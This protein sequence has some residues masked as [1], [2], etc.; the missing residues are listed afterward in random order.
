MWVQDVFL[1]RLLSFPHQTQ[2]PG[3]K[4]SPRGK[5]FLSIRLLCQFSGWLR[6]GLYFHEFI[7]VCSQLLSSRTVTTDH[8]EVGGTI[9]KTPPAGRHPLTFQAASVILL[10]SAP[11]EGRGGAAV[12]VPGR[13]WPCL[14]AL[15]FSSNL[16]HFFPL[17]NFKMKKFTDSLF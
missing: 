16:G 14:Q 5:T 8:L 17:R 2:S 13:G 7:F 3:S 1:S 10:V 12:T 11:G 4:I 9:S 6:S 15:Q